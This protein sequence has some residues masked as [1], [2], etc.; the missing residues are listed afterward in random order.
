MKLTVK[1]GG[2]A[3]TAAALAACG[4]GSDS[5]PE[6]KQYSQHEVKNVASLGVLVSGVVSNRAGF[7]LGLFGGTLVRYSTVAS[8]SVPMVQ[9]TCGL[10]NGKT[11]TLSRTITK[12]AFRTGLAAGDQISTTYANCDV[13]YG[14]VLNGMVVLTVQEPAV[15][16]TLNDYDS[17]FQASMSSFSMKAAVGDA[18]ILF[19]SIAGT[20]KMV[21]ANRFSGGF[22]VPNAHVFG[23][24]SGALVLSIGSGATYARTDVTYPDAATYVLNGDVTVAANGTNLPLRIATPNTLSGTIVNGYLAPRT[25]TITVKDLSRN[26]ATST[27]VNGVSA[28]VSG[29]TDGNGSMDL[30]F[31]STWAGLMSM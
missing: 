13:G 27:S 19:G 11:G 15:N 9:E 14:T 6:A 10:A 8:G 26:I 25:G 21:G 16:M 28:S 1:L 30:Q 29:D 22:T 4:G 23:I 31:S 2:C 5:A 20:A 3:V 7:A 17:H 18:S 12:S 24:S